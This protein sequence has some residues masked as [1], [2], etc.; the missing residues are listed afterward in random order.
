MA[1][2]LAA[3]LV[4]PDVSS[5]GTDG[6][7]ERCVLTGSN[8]AGLADAECATIE[9]PEDA[10]A[11]DGRRIPLFVARVR[12]TALEP[13]KE[14]LTL[15]SG[16]PGS[17][18]TQFYTDMAT[19]FRPALR[20]RDLLI[21]DQRGTGRSNALNCDSLETA[22]QAGATKGS[23]LAE[24]TRACLRNLPGDP[25]FYG[26]SPAVRDLD[27]VRDRLGYERLIL[28]GVSYGTRV[29]LHYARRYPQ[30]TRALVL[31]GVIPPGVTL[32]ANIALN[33]QAALDALLARC[34]TDET[35]AA[36]YPDAGAYLSTLRQRFG[37]G[38]IT[39]P[40]ENSLTAEPDEVDIGYGH[41]AAAV[42][43]LSYAPETA[44]IVPLLTQQAVNG[45]Y[46]PLAS[47]ALRIITHLNGLLSYGMHNA[48]VC[49]EDAPYF[50]D[51][52]VDWVRLAASYIGTDQYRAL[53]AMCDLWPAGRIDDDLREP[54][55]SAVPTLLLSGEF[56]PIT[57]PAYGDAVLES[58]TNAVHIVAPGQGH[59][60]IARGCIAG[61]AHDFVS[62]P[63]P[64][65]VDATC[66]QRLRPTPIFLNAMGPIAT[67]TPGLIP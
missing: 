36:H 65:A 30:R 38:S 45:H 6:A 7:F 59:G 48:V 10:D 41:V 8:G 56:D 62:S 31:D 25:V 26:T 52:Q 2:V 58:L 5:A 47:Q 16:G 55:V 39:V 23:A 66:V 43:I 1:A 3:L 50:D 22:S 51:D 61:I 37:A 17:A 24:A 32:G 14:P 19:V 60:V 46:R 67:P 27:A 64:G 13:A 42:R 18:A 57:P 4:G 40:F 20:E 63:D 33:A 11:P 12:S 35:C 29:A 53:K 44:A 28:Y 54:L 49:T 34:A 21:V 9:V 15:I